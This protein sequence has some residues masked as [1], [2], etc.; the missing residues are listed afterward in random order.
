M[1]LLD[2]NLEVLYQV[3][4]RCTTLVVCCLLLPWAQPAGCCVA[5][6]LSARLQTSQPKRSTF[7]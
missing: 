7:R 6:G 4:S 2:L 1:R 5:L 3:G